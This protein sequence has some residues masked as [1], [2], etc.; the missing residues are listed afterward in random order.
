MTLEKYQVNVYATLTVYA[1][2]ADEAY[3]LALNTCEEI[4][5]SEEF[6]IDT[7]D[8]PMLKVESP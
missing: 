2:N 8:D 4:E 5:C 6:E 3:E 7:I 1:E